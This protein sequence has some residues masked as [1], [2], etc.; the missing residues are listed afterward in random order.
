METENQKAGMRAGGDDAA[1]GS[2]RIDCPSCHALMVRGMR[3]CRL[4]GY[5]LGEGVAEYAE[6]RRFTGT[7]PTAARQ[8]PR[9]HASAPTAGPA[10]WPGGPSNLTAPVAPFV[11][12]NTTSFLKASPA[13]SCAKGGMSWVMW[14]VI[15]V[16]IMM[17]TSGAIF[18][19]FRQGRDGRGAAATDGA[20][21][22][23]F[24]ADN[25][26]D[27][28]GGGVMISAVEIP[29]PAERAKLIGG[30]VVKTFDG[31]PVGDEDAMRELLAR[32]PAGKTVEV[33]YVRDGE[34][35]QTTLTT[36]SQ[37]E[38]EPVDFEARPEGEGFLGIDPG[39]LDRVPVPNTDIHGVRLGEVHRN[40]PGYLAGLR[41][42]DVVI[43]FNEHLIRTE[44]EFLL[45]I[46]EALP[47][48]TV[49]AIVMRGS[50]RLEIPVK[51]GQE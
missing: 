28:A 20:P 10:A 33:T 12:L 49:K 19:Q 5:R 51:M 18:K 34:T 48:S 14:F 4:C 11:S 7:P 25:F 21:S 9:G 16:A 30:D 1:A 17:A 36:I 45:R 6:T 15:A 2:E 39:D 22:S 50:K 23:F 35:K 46:D 40:R 41:E 38:F 24:G 27:V 32:T 8:A 29:S 31:Q 43:E 47:D 37:K 44:K 42:G 3:F 26:E 13:R